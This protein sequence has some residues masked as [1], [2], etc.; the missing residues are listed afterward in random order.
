M[1]ERSKSRTRPRPLPGS[2]LLRPQPEL[3]KRALY[4]ARCRLRRPANPRLEESCTF[5]EKLLILH[6][7]QYL[8]SNS[9]TCGQDILSFG[10]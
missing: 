5:P 6:K 4:L 1:A 9:K 7:L 3:R 2:Q 8:K 10:D